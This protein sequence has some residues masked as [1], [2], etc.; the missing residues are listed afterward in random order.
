MII[1]ERQNYTRRRAMRF[2]IITGMSGAGKSQAAKVFEDM[3]YFV[4]D[5]MP[6]ALM[7]KFTEI[8][9]NTDSMIENIALVT[10]IRSGKLFETLEENIEYLK[11]K[12]VPFEVLFLDASDGDLVRRYKE[13]RRTHP[14][15]N[16]ER[17]INGIKKERELLSPMKKIADFDL[18]TTGMKIKKFQEI[19]KKRYTLEKD[20][21]PKLLINVTS[22]GFKYGVPVD[23]DLAFDVRFIE[24][25]F[26]IEELRPLS[27]KDEPVKE[28]VLKNE[29][30]VKFI[31]KL[32]DMLTFLIPHYIKEGKRQLII[33]IG[34]TGGRHRSVAITNEV[35]RLLSNKGFMAHSSHRDLEEDVKR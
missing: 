10:D 16:T 9:A 25:P 17:L 26:Y 7:G 32:M 28:F 1:I 31:E 20:E 12:N 13:S 34:C 24:N 35:A 15:S 19:L 18:D 6:P 3:G 27:G 30:T 5:N 23:V 14:L 11:Q 2:I 21:T 4:I 22:F 8:L 29:V 33:G